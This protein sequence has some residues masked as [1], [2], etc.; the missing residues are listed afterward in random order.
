[1]NT[2]Q[3][4]SALQHR[5]AFLRDCVRYPLLAGLA[6]LGGVLALRKGDPNF[7]EPCVKQRVCRGCGLFGDC[8]KPQ[9]VATRKGDQ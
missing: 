6:V 5:R 7:V 8:A 1:M 3:P 2:P 4:H 9:A